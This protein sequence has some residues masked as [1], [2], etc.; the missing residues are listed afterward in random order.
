[1]LRIRVSSRSFS[2]A[3]FEAWLGVEVPFEGMLEEM[4]YRSKVFE[5]VGG[6]EER[7]LTRAD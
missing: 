4:K 1:M 2:L 3:D 6:L 5:S 7:L